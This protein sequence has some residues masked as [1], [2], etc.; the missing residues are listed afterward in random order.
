MRVF[1][2]GATGFV[3]SAVVPELIK[4]GHRVLGLTPSVHGD[5]EHLRGRVDEHA[6]STEEN[7][8]CNGSE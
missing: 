5:G 7:R 3:G 4:A 2:T 6:K 8:S 1:V